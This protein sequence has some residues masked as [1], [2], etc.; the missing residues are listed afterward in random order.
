MPETKGLLV[1]GGGDRTGVGRS[2]GFV[3]YAGLDMPLFSVQPNG[4]SVKPLCHQFQS[5]SRMNLWRTI[6]II[7]IF[8]LSCS[9]VFVHASAISVYQQPFIFSISPKCS[10]AAPFPTV[11]VTVENTES[12]ELTGVIIAVLHD[13]VGRPLFVASG[14][15]TLAGGQNT[16]AFAGAYVSPGNYST[17]VFIW[18]INGSSL[19][20]S[21]TAIIPFC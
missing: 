3:R 9:S 14:S 18:S 6:A 17:N 2:P 10:E 5:L 20:A 1:L 4:Q 8:I 21:Q 12:S 7:S 13:S 19:S 16:T 11:N 15:I